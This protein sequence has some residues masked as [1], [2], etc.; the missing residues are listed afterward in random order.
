MP[1]KTRKSIGMWIQCDKCST[2]ILQKDIELHENDCPPDPTKHSYDYIRGE[3]LYGLA[4]VKNNEDIKNLSQN[5]KDNLVFLSQSVLQLC[6]LSIGSWAEIRSNKLNA[7]VARTVWPTTEKSVTSVLFTQASMELLS[8]K[9]DSVVTVTNIKSNVRDAKLITLV[10]L[11]GKKCIELTPELHTRIQKLYN[12]RLLAIGNKIEIMFFGKRLRFEVKEVQ[13]DTNENREL[14]QEF[15]DLTIYDEELFHITNSSKFIL[16]RSEVEYEK[17]Q[18]KDLFKDIG[19]LDEEIIEVKELVQAGLGET[20][21][22]FDIKP[23]KGCLL[24]GHSGTGK[25]LLANALSN[26]TNVFKTIICATDLYTI[27]AGNSQFALK[28]LFQD[29]MDNAPSLIILDEFDILCPSR[30]NRLTDLEKRTVSS[31]LTFF[32]ELNSKGSKIFVLGTT[33]KIDNIDPAFRRC[34]RF[35]RE[36]EIPTP[37]P[38]SR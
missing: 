19:G 32:D 4:G 17:E 11:E 28:D 14:V 12:S 31:V 16:F 24:Y 29:A 1:P 20:T 5:E 23:S 35:D 22:R 27:Y 37:N 15:C 9:A 10:L 26:S 38:T 18:S 25:T 30:S 13:C 3:T 7:P 33:N 34:G 6:S 36:I 8:L 2:N 21:S